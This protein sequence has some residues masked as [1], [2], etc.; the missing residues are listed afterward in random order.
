MKNK[1]AFSLIEISIVILII[2]IIIAAV[3]QSSR[4][5]AQIRLS[6][7]RSLTESSPAAGVDGMVAWYE[8]TSQKSF[9]DTE[10]SD[11]STISTWY[12]INPQSIVKHDMPQTTSSKRPFYDASSVN[13]LPALRFD[14]SS[15]YFEKSYTAELNTEQFTMFFVMQATRV[16]SGHGT[17]ISSRS[18]TGSILRGFTF[19]AMPSSATPANSY[20]MWTGNGVDWGLES[21]TPLTI[22]IK[23]P[24]VVT[25]IYNG[26]AVISYNNGALAGS[27]SET[28]Y[29]PNRDQ[30]IRIGAGVNEETTPLFFFDGHICEIIIYRRSLKSEERYAIEKYLGQK[31]GVRIS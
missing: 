31:W 11:E 13:N 9:V 14:G 24:Q 6:T 17:I 30:N 27:R 18:D 19:Y 4:V 20:A 10:A 1:K 7:A 12:D 26:S 22:Q 29:L 28:N 5:V 8:S 3:V 15:T 2:G 16:Y 25:I 23:K 21:Y